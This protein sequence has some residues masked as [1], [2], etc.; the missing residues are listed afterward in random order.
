MTFFLGK[1]NCCVG[2]G[3]RGEGSRDESAIPQ[4]PCQA[5]ASF[6][7][8]LLFRPPGSP[9]PPPS[10]PPPPTFGPTPPPFPPSF[11]SSF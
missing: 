3:E 2:Q 6:M 9:G 5:L 1:N 10:P 7:Q 8:Q 4:L 11:P